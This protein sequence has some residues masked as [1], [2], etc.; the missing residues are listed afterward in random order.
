TLIELLVV[1]IIIGI[2]AAVALPQ[3]Q[4]AVLKAHFATVM[5]NTKAIKDAA[6][7]Y[8][9]INGYY[10]TD[11]IV[12]LDID[13]P[14]CTKGGGGAMFCPQTKTQY[15]YNGNL[16]TGQLFD[17]YGFYPYPGGSMHH[18]ADSNH[19]I[20]YRVILDHAQSSQG[21]RYCRGNNAIGRRVCARMGGTKLNDSLW[22]LN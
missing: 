21:K 1:V 8:Y 18:E 6:E 13:I 14:G 22:E 12:P 9:M 4:V 20:V 16:N 5:T 19:Q 2:L 10:P 3:Y 7:M 11:N 15:N 17:I